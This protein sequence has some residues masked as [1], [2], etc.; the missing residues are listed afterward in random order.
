MNERIYQAFG[1]NL[2]PVPE[3]A[4]AQRDLSPATRSFLTSVGLPRKCPL[5]VTL[6]DDDRLLRPFTSAGITYYALGNDYGTTIGI[7]AKTDETWSFDEEGELPLRFINSRIQQFVAFLALYK[8]KQPDLQKAGDEEA[9]EI[10][11]ELRS[12]FAALDGRAVEDAENWWS[13][14]LEQTQDGFL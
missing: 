9:T 8:L 4:L 2:R 3:K 14:I 12:Q 6:Y 7:R 1:D 10:V 13:V 5:Q 11:N